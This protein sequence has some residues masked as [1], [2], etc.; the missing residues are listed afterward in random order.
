MENVALRLDLGFL[1]LVSESPV[2][3]FGNEIAR[4]IHD[5]NCE[6]VETALRLQKKI[7]EDS[8]FKLTRADREK[9]IP[10]KVFTPDT[11]LQK[12]KCRKQKEYSKNLRKI[13]RTS[14]KKGFIYMNAGLLLTPSL[15]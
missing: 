8:K 9:L 10:G 15:Q 14:I 4:E 3:I 11:A 2:K 6:L 1:S 7:A 13:L 5:M 12:D